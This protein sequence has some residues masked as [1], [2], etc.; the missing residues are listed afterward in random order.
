MMRPRSG[1]ARGS[2]ASLDALEA[3]L[4]GLWA[5]LGV[6]DLEAL[7]QRLH[8][9][10]EAQRALDGVLGELRSTAPEGV[11]ALEALRA[12]HRDKLRLAEQQFAEAR[13]ASLALGSLPEPPEAVDDAQW[14]RIDA[15]DQARLREELDARRHAGRV[16]RAEGPIAS[17]WPAGTDL[18]GDRPEAD[19]VRVV[20]GECDPHALSLCEARLHDERAQLGGR[21]R[22]DVTGCRRCEG[23]RL[24]RR[25][26]RR[27][28]RRLLRH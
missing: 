25:L 18:L 16:L 17:V 1:D 13:A 14:S 10:E 26:G 11:L 9:S 21:R 22:F 15:L 7:T 20:L 2:G 5:T 24:R 28:G 8:A 4:R 27:L 12:K 3:E 23:R 6:A 19:G